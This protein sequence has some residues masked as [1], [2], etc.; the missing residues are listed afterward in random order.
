MLQEEKKLELLLRLA[1]QVPYFQTIQDI[2]PRYDQATMSTIQ[3]QYLPIPDDINL[4]KQ[5]GHIPLLGFTDHKIIRD[6]RFRIMEALRMAG[7]QNTQAA[8]DVVQ[9]YHPRPHLAIH[10]IL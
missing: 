6:T 8:K 3:G 7:L 5:R 10:G 4:A 1:E 2:A 9:Q